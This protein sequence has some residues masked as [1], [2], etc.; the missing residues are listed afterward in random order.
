MSKEENAWAAGLF[1]GE[2]ST[3]VGVDRR[4]KNHR[5]YTY[6]R[7]HVGQTHDEDLY[8]P[9]VLE[10]FKNVVRVGKIFGPTTQFNGR[11][12]WDYCAQTFQEVQHVI[13]VIWPWLSDVKREQASLA[14]KT[15]LAYYASV[16]H[17]R[18]PKCLN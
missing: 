9:E 7:L 2:G 18:G 13:C 3:G 14:L 1:D 8:P 17:K 15:Y 5:E 10:R 4:S 16:D 6:L 11:F 12:R